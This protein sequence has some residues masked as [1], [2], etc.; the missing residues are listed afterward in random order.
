M[1]DLIRKKAVED[2]KYPRTCLGHLPVWSVLRPE[3]LDY[4]KS[5]SKGE[6]SIW[7]SG[8]LNEAGWMREPGSNSWSRK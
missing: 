7:L 2:L 3:V 6:Q 1:S 4:M 5:L 8:C